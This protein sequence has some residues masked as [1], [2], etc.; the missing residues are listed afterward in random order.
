MTKLNSRFG[1]KLL[2]FIPE[3]RGA[4]RLESIQGGAHVLFSGTESGDGFRVLPAVLDNLSENI[5]I[6]GDIVSAITVEREL[7]SE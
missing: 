6:V 2:Q 5:T 3:I 4:T 7:D 1:I